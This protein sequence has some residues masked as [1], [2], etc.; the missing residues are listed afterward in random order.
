VE[1]LDA[2]PMVKPGMTAAVT[3]TVREVEDA[4]IVPNRAV[5]VLNGQRVVYLLVNNRPVAVEV[6]LGTS[7]D[8]YSEVLEGDLAA[9]DLLVLNPAIP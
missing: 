3:V 8:F 2:D 4:L 5:R 1:L 9:G 6:R 7:T